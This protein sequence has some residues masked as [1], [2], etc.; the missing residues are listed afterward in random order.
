MF[1]CAFTCFAC[2]ASEDTG[3]RPCQRL[4][5][6]QLPGC[7]DFCDFPPETSPPEASTGPT[8]KGSISLGEEM[9]HLL[10]FQMFTSDKISEEWWAPS[11]HLH[12]P[13]EA[14]KTVASKE[15]S[16]RGCSSVIQYSSPGDPAMLNRSRGKRPPRAPLRVPWHHMALTCPY[17]SNKTSSSAANGTSHHRSG[18][19]FAA[20]CNKVDKLDMR[21]MST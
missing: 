1:S 5:A 8:G 2:L 3:H 4:V 17:D 6:V 9:S 11:A 7:C 13:K 15:G 12:L 20:P 19:W 18:H 10:R 14:L 21:S 16:D